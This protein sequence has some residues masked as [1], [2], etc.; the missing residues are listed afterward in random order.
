[1]SAGE[2]RPKVNM[3]RGLA[4]AILC[5]FG[6]ALV[7]FGLAFGG[8]LLEGAKRHGA[9]ALWAGNAVWLPLMLP[10][11]IPNFVYCIYLLKKNKKVDRYCRPG[12]ASPLLLSAVIA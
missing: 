2:G 7:N 3:S 12:T 10:G 4:F 6:A 9:A 5:G 8:P 1:M 11:S